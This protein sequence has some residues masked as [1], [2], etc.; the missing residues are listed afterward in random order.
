MDKMR[1]EFEAWC[2]EEGFAVDKYSVEDCG[3]KYEHLVGE[4]VLQETD[5]MWSSWQASRT[6]LRDELKRAVFSED[7]HGSGLILSERVFEAIGDHSK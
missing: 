4:Y 7:K 5:M 2:D 6:T 3:E 1:Q